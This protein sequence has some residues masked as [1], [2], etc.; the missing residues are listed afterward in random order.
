METITAIGIQEALDH[1][2]VQGCSVAVVS[3]EGKYGPWK[4]DFICSG[5]RNSKGEGVDK[6][7]RPRLPPELR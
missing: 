3:R 1:W 4:D 6:D 7:V 5:K 2:G